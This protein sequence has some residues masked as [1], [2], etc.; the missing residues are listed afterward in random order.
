M[1]WNEGQLFARPS[2]IGSLKG[3]LYYEL[4]L[5]R[6]AFVARNLTELP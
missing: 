2:S 5:P 1:V 3:R 6:G 4:Q